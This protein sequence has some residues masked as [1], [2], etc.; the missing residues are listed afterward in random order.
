[1]PA[2]VNYGLSVPAMPTGSL[3][4]ILA[5]LLFMVTGPSRM[6]ALSINFIF[7]ALFQCG[8][9]GTVS[10]YT[11]RWSAAFFALGLLLT[12]L[13]PF[14]YAGG[15]FDFRLDFGGFCLFGLMV[16]AVVRSRFF[17]SR[18]WALVVGLAAAAL[19]LYRHLT[20]VYLTGIF[21][22]CLLFV[23]GRMAWQ[24]REG[25][26]RRRAFRQL[27]SGAIS[28]IIIVG[29]TLPALLAKWDYLWN[30]YVI[31]HLLGEEKKV[32]EAE[33]GV[34]NRL[35]SYLFYLKSADFHAGTVFWITAASCAAVGLLLCLFFGLRR[36]LAAKKTPV[37]CTPGLP[38][39]DLAFM[40]VF[41]LACLFVPY[42]VLTADIAKSYV[43]GNV[44]V[45]GLM[46]LAMLPLLSLA[47]R[48]LKGIFWQGAGALG[49]LA[50][51]ISGVL[52]QEHAYRQNQFSGTH[53]DDAQQ[54]VAIQNDIVRQS[55]EH[56]LKRPKLACDF[57]VEFLCA[58][59]T[60]VWA[61]ETQGRMLPVD[62]SAG[63]NILLS[64][65]KAILDWVNQS[66]FVLLSSGSVYA[67]D[68]YPFHRRMKELRPQLASYCERELVHVQTYHVLDTT[69]QLYVRPG[70]S[71]SPKP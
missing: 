20:I 58:P 12:A 25:D 52:V 34:T 17:L 29:V 5:P 1:V 47:R 46:W 4:H 35:E 70:V 21:G 57:I 11:R 50:V 51:L 6:A 54:I 71:N 55:M 7:Y 60:S 36:L 30:Y 8:L 22:I 39:I 3:L 18:R 28:A 66:D 31:G 13:A 14:F 49:A 64:D 33:V 42:A 67:S 59:V 56:G 15:L 37:A 41:F 63:L 9:A 40:W 19:T 48:S 53:P 32:R 38:R 45:V 44:L 61:Y 2:G 27:T 10:W 23:L 69:L 68:A 24:W 43:P 65:D 62:Q 16:C 26:C